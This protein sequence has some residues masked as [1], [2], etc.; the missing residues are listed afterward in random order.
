MGV[1]N[2]SLMDPILPDPETIYSQTLNSTMGILT[3]LLTRIPIFHLRKGS[4]SCTPN[5]TL[6]RSVLLK[7][8]KYYMGDMVNG[9]SIRIDS[10]LIGEI[11]LTR[12]NKDCISLKQGAY[13]PLLAPFWPP[14]GPI[15]IPYLSNPH[16]PMIP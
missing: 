3:G 11:G 16:D 12:N 15:I 2:R 13:Y 14:F 10:R 9:I 8:P 4:K 1:P 7:R 5:R 6:P